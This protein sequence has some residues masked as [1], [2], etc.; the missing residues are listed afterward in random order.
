MKTKLTVSPTLNLMLDKEKRIYSFVEDV[1]LITS[2]Y[3]AA[4]ARYYIGYF[5]KVTYTNAYFIVNF[6]TNGSRYVYTSDN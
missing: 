4:L 1:I 3:N 6:I 5:V 2:K